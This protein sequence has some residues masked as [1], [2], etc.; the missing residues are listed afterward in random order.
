DALDQ[1]LRKALIPHYPTLSELRL[2]DYKVVI[3]DAMRA[4]EAHVRVTIESADHHDA[5]VTVGASA[6][7]IE[8]SYLAL[9]DSLEYKLLKGRRKGRGRSTA[10]R[11]SRSR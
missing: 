10:K 9:L 1:A 5:W 4:T 6:N 2:V 3:V 8:A 7:I 11:S